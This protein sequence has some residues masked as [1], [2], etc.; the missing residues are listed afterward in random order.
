MAIAWTTEIGADTPR[1]IDV[2]KLTGKDFLAWLRRQVRDRGRRASLGYIGDHVERPL[3]LWLKD[4]LGISGGHF[5]VGSVDGFEYQGQRHYLSTAFEGLSICVL[6]GDTDSLP[7]CGYREITA[8]EMLSE[9]LQYID[10]KTP[11]IG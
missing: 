11:L 2:T 5:E 3:E 8:W 9:A 10:N 6:E 7:E 1:Q 4:T